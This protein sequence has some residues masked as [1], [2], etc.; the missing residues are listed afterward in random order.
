M[1]FPM[2]G[3]GLLKEEGAAPC[4][5]AVT[6]DSSL[7][8]RL[9]LYPRYVNPPAQEVFFTGK[10]GMKESGKIVA[11]PTVGD[12]LP[13]VEGAFPPGGVVLP[14]DSAAVLKVR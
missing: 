8:E 4:G 14:A 12:P 7:A 2:A 9:P 13:E 1:P 11:L 10:G 6:A 3:I 5:A